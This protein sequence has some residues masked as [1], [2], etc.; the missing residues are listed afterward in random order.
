MSREKNTER[1]E[2]YVG[3]QMLADLSTVAL[4]A[5][6]DELSPYIRKV[7]REHVYGHFSGQSSLLEAPKRGS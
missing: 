4:T 5:G 7:L 1:V 6:F 3:E 2:L